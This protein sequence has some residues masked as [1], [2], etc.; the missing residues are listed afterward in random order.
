MQILKKVYILI[1]HEKLKILCTYVFFMRPM[2]I[3]LRRFEK[4]SKVGLFP[5][6]F[7]FP[8][9]QQKKTKNS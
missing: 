3:F 4:N 8:K 9:F 1:D 2:D 5:K 6:K 7:F